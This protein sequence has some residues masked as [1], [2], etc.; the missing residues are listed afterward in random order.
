[1][2]KPTNESGGYIIKRPVTKPRTRLDGGSGIQMSLVW[3]GRLARLDFSAFDDIRSEPRATTNAVL[4]VYVASLFAGAGSWLWAV[5]SPDFAGLDR[6]EVFVKSL[7]IGSFTQTVIWFAWVYI[8]YQVLVR[9]YGSQV[10]FVDLTRTM[11][12]AFAPVAISVLIA[13]AGFAIPFGLLAFGI[14]LLLTTAAIE[15]AADTEQREAMI[16]NLTGFAVFLVFMGMCANISEVATFGG[17]SPGILFF[18]LDL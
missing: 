16:A 1:V 4:V 18:S 8:A 12:Y 10:H 5:Q 3:L 15:Y 14:T 9:A 7:I 17:I 6:M 2:P 11:G 13:I